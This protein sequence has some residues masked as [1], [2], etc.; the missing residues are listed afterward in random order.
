MVQLRD[1]G[2][3]LGLFQT[4]LRDLVRRPLLVLLSE[5]YLP[6]QSLDCLLL[7]GIRIRPFVHLGQGALRFLQL[8]P[9]IFGTLRYSLLLLFEG[10]DTAVIELDL[11]LSL[12]QGPVQ[13][14]LL[15]SQG[16]DA[17]RLSLKVCSDL[18]GLGVKLLQ[19]LI[20]VLKIFPKF[21]AAIK[22]DTGF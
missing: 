7:L 9:V 12:L 16:F 15:C 11:P 14:L 3:G 8:V 5:L 1:R 21:G 19:V 18:F 17:V 4:I 2:L 6:R 13:V 10:F 20:D 22:A